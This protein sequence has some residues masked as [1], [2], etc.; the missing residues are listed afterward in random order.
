MSDYRNDRT[1]TLPAGATPRIVAR[2]PTGAISVHGEERDDVAVLV[3]VSP[4]EAIGR[5]M[6]VVVEQEGETIRAEVRGQQHAPFGWLRGSFGNLR[7]AI[8]IRTPRRS[9]VEADGASA[10]VHLE[11]LTGTIRA[12]TASGDVRVADLSGEI[13][14]Q[15][16]SGD[17]GA[18]ALDGAVRI[19]SASGDVKVE[20]AARELEIQTASGDIALDGI[21]GTLSV[22]S[23][24]GDCAARASA[25]S[26]C[27][28]KTA[29]GDLNIATALAPDGDYEFQTVSG[30]L[31][32]FVPQETR[33][34]VTIKTVSGDLS[35]ALPATSDGGN[36][37][38]RSLTIN[39]GGVP[40][41]VK[42]VSGDCTIRASRE[43]LPSLP[44]TAA[45]PAPPAR[46]PMPV[47]PPIPPL[48]PLPPSVVPAAAAGAIATPAQGEEPEDTMSETLSV[49]RAVERGELSIDEAMER[50]A[51]LEGAE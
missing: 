25:L 43:Q 6:E 29:S 8:E 45:R 44:A 11:H 21:T 18:H 22:G 1:F 30:D 15:T 23:A 20:R 9:D 35:T 34:T 50:L 12:R 33:A 16:A 32:L 13:V 38:N 28:A 48:P 39:G 37:R 14:I 26:S 24:S 42:T 5:D 41:R 7:I 51:Q 36:K 49:L 3:T 4:E 47:A 17:V 19:N 40:V 27:R 10:N 46:P 2:T 31:A